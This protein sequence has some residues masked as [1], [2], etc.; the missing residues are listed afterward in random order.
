[1][2]RSTIIAAV[3]A[4]AAS[5]QSCILEDRSH[6][7]AY[8]TLD[9]SST[10]AEVSH[11]NLIIKCADG[12]VF[13]DSI[14]S[15]RFTSVYEIPVPRGRAGIAAFGNIECMEFADGY[16]ITTG[17]E[18]DNVYTCFFPAVYDRDLCSD[19]V[20]LLKNNIGLHIRITGDSTDSLYTVITSSSVGYDLQGEILEGEYVYTPEAAHQTEG[21][22]QYLEFF[23]RVIR[24]KND[25]L[26]M[27]V[28][29]P[30]G[31]ILKVLPLSSYL[32]EAGIDMSDEELDDLYLTL[33]LAEAR[34]VISPIDWTDTGNI[35]ISI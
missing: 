24:Q 14:T 19:S 34:L 7:P 31:E 16:R 20:R 2:R 25:D 8:L 33:D 35:Q 1:M 5:V 13:T 6:C 4:M 29:G 10:P 3:V 32:D 15:D 30:G 22:R 11:I 28:Y 17:N 18:A 12:S 23:C 27:S 9:F 21:E 26:S